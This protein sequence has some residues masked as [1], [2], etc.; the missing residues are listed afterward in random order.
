M[1]IYVNGSPVSGDRRT[2]YIGSGATTLGSSYEMMMYE[3]EYATAAPH[4]ESDADMTHY[5]RFLFIVFGVFTFF[6]CT[7]MG[8][9]ARFVLS[10][11]IHFLPWKKLND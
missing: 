5:M 6:A 8:W 3:G 1:K 4:D 11:K 10:G 7:G 9:M 2:V